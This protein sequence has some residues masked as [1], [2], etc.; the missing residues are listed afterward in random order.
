VDIRHDVD[1]PT[2]VFRKAREAAA[3]VQGEKGSPQHLNVLVC[4]ASDRE[5]VSVSAP[6]WLARKVGS[7]ALHDERNDGIEFARRCL[8]PANLDKAGLGVL[9]EVE[10]DEGDQ[11]LIWLR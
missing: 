4:D 7:L 2:P 8:D 6:L 3:R 10:A 11:V 1:D 9:V 5:L